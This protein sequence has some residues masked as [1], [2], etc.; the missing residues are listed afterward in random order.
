[1]PPLPRRPMLLCGGQA[2]CGPS[3]SAGQIS[4]AAALREGQAAAGV[5]RRPPARGRILIFLEE[6]IC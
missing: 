3:R 2:A 6:R 5:D 4:W 1:M